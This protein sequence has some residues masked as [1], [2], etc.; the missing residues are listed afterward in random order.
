MLIQPYRE[1]LSFDDEVPSSE[2]STGLGSLIKRV[3]AGKR[4]LVWQGRDRRPLAVF[5]PLPPELWGY[6]LETGVVSD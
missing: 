3:A 2:L 4:V 1:G 5:A 6:L